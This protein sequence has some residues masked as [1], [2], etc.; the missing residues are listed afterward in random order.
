MEGVISSLRTTVATQSQTIQDHTA[1]IHTLEKAA[2]NQPGGDPTATTGR[3]MQDAPSSTK[4]VHI[5]RTSVRLPEGPG[6]RTSGNYNGGRHRILQGSTCGPARAK[7]VQ[8]ECCNEP[9]EDCS[10]GAP[11]TCNPGCAAVFLPFW[12]DCAAQ[13]HL[14]G[15]PLYE[16]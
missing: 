4:V 3:R 2:P 12:S 11:R 9:S 16:Q 15:T 5:H 7:A 6:W 10:G 1:R 8:T 13:L 14:Q